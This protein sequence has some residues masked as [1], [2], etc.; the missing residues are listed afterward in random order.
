MKEKCFSIGKDTVSHR[1]KQPTEWEAK[2][3]PFLLSKGIKY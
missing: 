1:K 3:C 2:F